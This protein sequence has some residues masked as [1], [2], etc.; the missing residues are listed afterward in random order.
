MI[1]SPSAAV[2]EIGRNPLLQIKGIG[3]SEVKFES[4]PDVSRVTFVIHGENLDFD[5]ISSEL[6]LLPTHTHRK[7]E[8]NR[9]GEVFPHDM[10]ALTAPIP[11]SEQPLDSALKWLIDNLEPHYGF[12]TSLKDK[13][14]IHIYC[15]IT[16]DL[17]QSGFSLSSD[18]FTIFTKLGIP[19]HMSILAI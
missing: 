6:A 11:S 16:T 9:L 18:A 5:V 8:L 15:G 4:H 1:Q 7:G 13:A 12:I 19:M 3:M 2:C 10:W 17:E 14:D